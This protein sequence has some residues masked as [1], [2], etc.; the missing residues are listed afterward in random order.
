VSGAPRLSRRHFVVVL[1]A[2][3]AGVARRAAAQ[4]EAAK[5][6]IDSGSATAVGGDE[7]RIGGATMGGEGY[8]PVRREPKPGATPSMTPEK[9]DALERGL[10][11][12]CPCTLDVFT[13]RTSMPCGFSPNMHTDVVRLVEG[14]YSGDEIMAAFVGAYG[15]KVLM[16][17]TKEGF[18]LLGWLMPFLVIGTG[19]VALASMLRRWGRRG[20]ETRLPAGVSAPAAATPSEMA[21]LEAAL[22]DED[23]RP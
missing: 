15:E 10:S 8:I 23:D 18:N 4:Q 6:P 9:R 12:P 11:C 22:R 1:G 19:G 20:D 16:A 13:C 3:G 17:P 21:R 5:G 7:S 2:I 14:G